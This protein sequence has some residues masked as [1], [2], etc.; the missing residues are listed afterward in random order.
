M[1]TTSQLNA[2]ANDASFRARIRNLVLQQ[3]AA[4]Y[5]EN[6]GTTGHAARV[7]FAIKVI[8]TP[9][10]ADELAKVLVTRTNLTVSA[11]S[12][13]WDRGVIQTDASDAAIFSQIAADWNLLAGV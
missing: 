9:S 1:A 6:S 2:L 5:A 7:A 3:A 12:Y 8:Q 11:V 13:D 10:L 4:V